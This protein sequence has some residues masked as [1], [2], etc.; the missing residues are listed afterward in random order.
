MDFN[1]RK[2]APHENRPAQRRVVRQS[3][4]GCSFR[5]AMQKLCMASCLTFSTMCSAPRMSY[6]DLCTTVT[7]P[8][9]LSAEPQTSTSR[10]RL[11]RT[12][13][14]GTLMETVS[15]MKT[16]SLPRCA[17]ALSLWP[18]RFCCSRTKKIQLPAV[19]IWCLAGRNNFRT[20][21]TQSSAFLTVAKLWTRHSAAPSQHVGQAAAALSNEKSKPCSHA[22][23][24]EHDL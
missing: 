2:A 23:Q 12:W 9:S 1:C 20:E 22:K 11:T 24:K 3:A 6:A 14:H 4:S 5:S 17:A 10:R 18:K 13:V 21:S 7:S 19:C 8:T 15:L 16:V